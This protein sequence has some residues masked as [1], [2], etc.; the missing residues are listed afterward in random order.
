[1]RQILHISKGYETKMQ[2]KIREP[3]KNYLAAVPSGYPNPTR[4]PVF[5]LIP[6]PIQFYK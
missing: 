6:D 2:Q 4:Y 1:M 5:L 3:V